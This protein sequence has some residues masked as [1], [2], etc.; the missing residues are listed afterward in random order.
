LIASALTT[1]RLV[2]PFRNYFVHSFLGDLPAQIRAHLCDVFPDLLDF[3]ASYV[4]RTAGQFHQLL[5]CL[6]TGGRGNQQPQSNSTSYPDQKLQHES[7]SCL[8]LREMHGKGLWF[9]RLNEDS[10]MGAKPDLERRKKGNKAAAPES[11]YQ[12]F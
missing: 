10:V 5:A 12:L 11:A 4:C 6:F 9:C 3:L 2:Q 8:L 7:P 1:A